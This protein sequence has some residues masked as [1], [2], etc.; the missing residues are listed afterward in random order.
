LTLRTCTDKEQH[1]QR[2]GS[3]PAALL[4]RTR[5]SGGRRLDTE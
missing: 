3:N 4:P 5:C 2:R 1:K